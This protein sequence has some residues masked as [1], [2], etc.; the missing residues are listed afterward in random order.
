[1]DRVPAYDEPFDAVVMA[2]FGE[3]FARRGKPAVIV[4]D[5]EMTSRALLEWI[6]RNGLAWHYIAPGKP[7]QNRFVESLIGRLRDEFLNEHLFPSLRHARDLLD[8]WRDDHN[9]VS[10]HP[11]VYVVEVKRFC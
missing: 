4:I 6:N 11:S 2:G 9:P 1:M 3:H 10:L 7:Q 8:A 5:N